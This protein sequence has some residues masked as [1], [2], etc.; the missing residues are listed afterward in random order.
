MAIEYSEI[1]AATAMFFDTRVLDTAAESEESLIEWIGKAAVKARSNK[2]KYGSNDTQFTNYMA[3]NVGSLPD[4][5]KVAVLKN[6]LQGI[7]GAKAIKQ[8]LNSEH[9]EPRDVKA[10][11]LYMTGNTW[12]RTVISL[13]LMLLGLMI[14]MLRILLCIQ[15]IRIFMVLH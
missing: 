14:I 3:Q 4:A 15:E 6:A 8:W 12:P 2:I 11:N 5:A 10:K 7:S 1:M 9:G 13:G